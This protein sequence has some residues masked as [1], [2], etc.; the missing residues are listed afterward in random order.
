MKIQSKVRP[1]VVTEEGRT[2]TI[3]YDNRGEPFR[4]GVGITFESEHSKEPAVWVLLDV[5]EVVLL[6]DKL[7]EF[8]GHVAKATDRKDLVGLLPVVHNGKSAE[9]WYQ[10]YA[11]MTKLLADTHT[12]WQPMASAPADGTRL[13]CWYARWPDCVFT[14][15][16]VHG[17]WQTSDDAMYGIAPSKW[18]P[19]MLLPAIDGAA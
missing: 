11:S 6:R 2:V 13:L 10:L 19:L 14:A 8:L 12:P 15:W 3:Q 9:E 4:E 5:R 7:N 18:R 17:M 16:C 1:L